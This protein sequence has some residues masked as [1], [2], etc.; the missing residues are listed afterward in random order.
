M[1][2]TDQPDDGEQ[3]ADADS[4]ETGRSYSAAEISRRVK[5]R[6]PRL[7]P[8]DDA[9]RLAEQLLAEVIQQETDRAAARSNPDDDGWGDTLS[10][11][12]LRSIARA[13][14]NASRRK[15]QGD[16]DRMLADLADELALTDIRIL[17]LAAEAAVAATPRAIK[18]AKDRGMKPPE[19]AD[20]LGLTPSRVY[21]VL[22][23]L[24]AEQPPTDG[25]Q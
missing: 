5:G 20:E 25:D 15:E 3:R 21:Q 4:Y 9:R 18:A 16:L 14:R 23:E 1:N 22:R 17:R 10:R 11:A 13:Y 6:R 2:A 8:T 19:I 12:N 24:D 7:E